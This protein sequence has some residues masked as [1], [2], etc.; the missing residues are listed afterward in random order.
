DAPGQ[1]TLGMSRYAIAF[2]ADNNDPFSPAEIGLEN[3]L[4]IHY[5]AINRQLRELQE[6]RFNSPFNTDDPQECA[7]G[8]LYSFGVVGVDTGR[9]AEDVSNAEPV[10]NAQDSAE[11]TGVLYAVE[12]EGK[13]AGHLFRRYI[14]FRDSGDGQGLVGCIQGRNL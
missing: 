2:V 6:Q 12:V 9:R 10:G 13:A 5:C 3:I 11:I 1:E 8:G 14:H 7:H 4:A